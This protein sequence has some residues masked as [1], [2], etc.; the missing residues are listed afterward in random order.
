MSK[1]ALRE[2]FP[3]TQIPETAITLRTGD[4]QHY[5]QVDKIIKIKQGSL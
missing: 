1:M 3:G 5:I 2:E 4:N